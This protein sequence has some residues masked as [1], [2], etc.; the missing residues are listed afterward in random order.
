LDNLFLDRFLFP[1]IPP[2]VTILLSPLQEL[3]SQ[4]RA[5]LFPK[6]LFSNPQTLNGARWGSSGCQED[7]EPLLRRVSSLFF[8]TLRASPP[9]SFLRMTHQRIEPPPVLVLRSQASTR[10]LRPSQLPYPVP[11]PGPDYPSTAPNFSF[12]RI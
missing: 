2:P 5:H 11:P 7:W 1:A 4:Q 12:F 6:A 10:L 3:C 8:P 9:G